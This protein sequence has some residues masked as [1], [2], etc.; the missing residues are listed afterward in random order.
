MNKII[1]KIFII[2]VILML[3]MGFNS[4]YKSLSIDNLAYVIALGIDIGENEK[5]NVT[6]Q[7]TTGTPNPET[8][9]SE[10]NPSIV[11]SIEANSIDSAINIMNVYMAK[12]LNLSHCRVFVFSEQVA[13]NGISNEIYTLINDTEVRPSSNIIVCK[14]KAKDYIESSEPILENLITKYYEL[15]PNSSKYTGYLYNVTLGQFFN[16]LISTTSE[17]FAILGGVNNNSTD[18]SALSNASNIADIKATDN[19]ISAKRGSENIGTAVFKDD[20]L[21]GEL[22]ALE[23]LCLSIVKGEVESFLIS[24]NNPEN[25]QEKVDLMFNLEKSPKIKV[26]IVNNTPYVTIDLSFSGKVYSMKKDSKYMNST[27]LDS[28]SEEANKYLEKIITEYLYKTSVEFKSDINGIGEYALSNFLTIAEFEKF[29]WENSYSN[30][31]FK[32]TIDANV[33]SGFLL[34]ET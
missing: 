28:L 34:T 23:T 26:Y 21:V 32:V 17:P 4:S 29:D 3:I 9:S 30:S 8:G 5:Y 31:T 14:N 22:T 20:K 7:F 11:N 18:S 25:Q 19:S 10:K 6:F 1:K 13:A 27:T 33:Q 2:A 16:Q 24:V 12:Q 15:F